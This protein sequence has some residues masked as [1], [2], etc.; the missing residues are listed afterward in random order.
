ML[1]SCAADTRRRG[2]GQ[3]YSRQTTTTAIADSDFSA[4]RQTLRLSSAA[5]RTGRK[6]PCGG[7][8]WCARLANNG[9]FYS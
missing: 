2:G 5:K 4:E 6:Q 8:S 9:H 3:R 1:V 7:R